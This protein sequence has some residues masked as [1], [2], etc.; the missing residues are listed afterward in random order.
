M[1]QLRTP[2]QTVCHLQ[3]VQF[4]YKGIVP[5]IVFP[6]VNGLVVNDWSVFSGNCGQFSAGKYN[7]GNVLQFTRVDRFRFHRLLALLYS[8]EY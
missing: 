1:S 8:C 4:L 2:F 3:L 6:L 5:P 7:I